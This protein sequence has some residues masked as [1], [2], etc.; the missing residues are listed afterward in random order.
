MSSAAAR[1]VRTA[2]VE[3]ETMWPERAVFVEIEGGYRVW[4]KRVGRSGVPLLTLHGGPGFSHEIFTGLA[5]HLPS[6]DIDVILYDQLGSLNSDCPNDPALWTIP[7]FTFEVEQVRSALGL[8]SFYLL[9]LSWGGILGIEYALRHPQRLRGLIV[10]SMTASISSYQA[11]V[12]AL[13]AVLPAEVQEVLTAHEAAGTIE[14]PE[15]VRLID[16]HLNQ[17]HLCRVTPWPQS[18]QNMFRHANH[19]VYT[20]MQGPNEFMITGTLATWDRWDDLARIEPPTKLIV[21]KHDTISVA[22]VHEMARRIP[23]ASVTVCE[24]GSHFAMWDDPDTYRDAVIRFI[25]ETEE[26]INAN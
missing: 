23:R 2:E 21:G 8:E 10:S 18:V 26:K 6:D 24:R 19:K 20:T 17:R 15:Y 11:S 22:D 12:D 14:H 1:R 25:R 9:G 13:R 4:T 3:G 5:R 16:K 7:R